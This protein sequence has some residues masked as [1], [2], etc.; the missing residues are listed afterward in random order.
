MADETLLSASTV[1]MF[2]KK[3][4][5]LKL[6]PNPYN[7]Q[8]GA[9]VFLKKNLKLEGAHFARIYSFA[10]D[11]GFYD[12]DTPALFLVQGPGEDPNAP[13]PAGN[14]PP[15]PGDV[16][17]VGV[18]AQG[19]SFAP[20]VRVWT[21]DASEFLIRLDVSSGMLEEILLFAELG[22]YD[23]GMVGGGKVGGGK[24]GGGK[25]GGGK[26]GGGKV[27]GGKVGGGKVGGG[28]VGGGKVGGGKVGG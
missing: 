27:G 20:D 19:A 2:G 12:L 22:D 4:A 28:K 8:Q 13:R 5:D 21:Y 11:G 14:V 16:A 26:V 9:N 17:E 6:E 7:E 3:I 24:V 10:F 1:L 25:V 23:D 18:A 15:G